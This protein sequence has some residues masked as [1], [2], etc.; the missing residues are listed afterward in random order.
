MKKIIKILI[1]IIENKYLSLKE[2]YAVRS[3]VKKFKDPKRV[4]IWSEIILTQEQKN[5]IDELYIKNY[6][7]KIPYTWHRHFTAFTGNFDKN[8]FPEH[9]YIPKFENYMNPDKAYEKVF[10]DKN[11]LSYFA[12]N[13]GVLTP[14]TYFSCVTGLYRDEFNKIITKDQLFENLKNIGEVFIKPSTD[15][16]SGE[17]CALINIENGIDKYS[18]KNIF[19]IVE[20][21]GKN[22]IIQEKLICHETIKKLY[23]NSVNTFRVITYRWKDKIENCPVLMR[24]GQGGKNVDNAH[25]GGMF[26]AVEEDGRLHE[27]A[28]TEFKK[29]YIYH[30]DSKIIFKNY[31]IPNIDKI[32]EA[33]K[34]MHSLLPQIGSYNWD[35]TLNQEGKPVLIEANIGN[36]SIWL[37]QMSHGKGAF[38]ERT[39]EILRWIA[40]LEKLKKSER[41]DYAFGYINI[42]K[43]I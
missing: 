20:K 28:F 2:I 24:I 43:K 30:P 9:L 17:G 25:A 21:L 12:S 6:G 37:P 19:E 10:S 1:R 31:R 27:K 26:I 40:K 11:L 18:N 4:K 35:F 15:S 3:E 42:E 41:D 22:F 39:P 14:K 7:K 23:P 36:G 5:E 34:N 16:C 8:Y 13:I 33:A 38:G 32:I 29:E